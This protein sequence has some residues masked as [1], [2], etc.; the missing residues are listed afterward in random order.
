M[1]S[2]RRGTGDPV[3]SVI[4]MLARKWWPAPEELPLGKQV[5]ID[6]EGVFLDYVLYDEHG[7]RTFGVT[8]LD[9]QFKIP[10]AAVT[11]LEKEVRA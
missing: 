8:F 3:S 5:E 10:A 11:R 9:R 7:V 2:D 1:G 4:K 6:L